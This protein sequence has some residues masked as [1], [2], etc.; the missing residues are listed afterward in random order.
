MFMNFR[1][2]EHKLRHRTRM[3][4]AWMCASQSL[5]ASSSSFDR[6]RTGFAMLHGLGSWLRVGSSALEP[7]FGF[8]V[9]GK[10]LHALLLRRELPILRRAQ[11]R[12]IASGQL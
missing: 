6:L 5:A 1:S 4:P 12:S 7:A 8:S 11:D 2:D 9:W 3:R 10:V